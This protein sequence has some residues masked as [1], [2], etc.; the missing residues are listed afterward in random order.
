MAE[1]NEVK[2]PHPKRRLILKA[3]LEVFTEKGFYKAKMEEIA[4]QAGV[5]KGTIYEYFSSKENLFCETLK[6]SMEIYGRLITEEMEKG[7]T[8]REKLF[9]LIK[10]TYEIGEQFRPLANIVILERSI[11]DKDFMEW[12]MEEHLSRLQVLEQ[13]IREGVERGELR[14]VNEKIA[15]RIF[16]GGSGVFM[17]PE[18]LEGIDLQQEQLVEE[19]INCYLKGLYK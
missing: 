19:I 14:P 10:K 6:E 18:L 7:Q 8:V 3:A 2:N 17:R 13:I 9:R 1:I 11:I 12:I 4:Q 5:G 15:A 16:F